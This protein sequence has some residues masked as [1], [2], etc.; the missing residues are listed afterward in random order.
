MLDKYSYDFTDLARREEA[1]FLIGHEDEYR[2]MVDALSRPMNPNA[3]LVGESG[4]GKETIVA[5]LAFEIVKDEVPPAIFDKRLVAL[6]LSNLVAG[7]GP[8]E[9]QERLGKIVEEIA[10]AGNIILYIPDIHNLV[11]TSGTAYLSAAD[12]LIP[13]I[14]NNAFPVVGATYPKEFKEFLEPR[15]DF[16]GSFEVIRVEE[17][18]EAEA[19][20]LL[21]YESLL[22]ENKY[23]ITISF[24]AI[25][26]AVKLAKKYFHNKFLP[27]SAQE[28]LRGGVAL[29]A[30]HKEKILGPQRIIDAAEEKINIPIHEAGK[31]EAEALLN[32]E[33]AIHKRL[34]D[35]EEAVKAVSNAI[36]EYRSGLSRAGGPIATFLFVG[37]TGVGK[38]ELS[39]ILAKIQFG[40]EQMMIRFDM[41][42]YQDKQSFF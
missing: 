31:A 33:E 2:R 41:T 40:S 36:R 18:S 38:T 37:P 21:V 39:K 19:E 4:I 27:A 6:Q 23:K 3:M 10:I 42:E 13:I 28:L 16:V 25:K 26:T 32:L 7:A 9:L 15:S 24:G 34:I 8:E 35:Q 30:R 17:I 20:K 12:A 1:G 22:L 14:S 29:V 5:H 11:R